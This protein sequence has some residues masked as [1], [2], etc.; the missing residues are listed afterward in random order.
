VGCC[1]LHIFWENVAEVRAFAVKPEFARQGIGTKLAQA[2]LEEAEEL[3]MKEVFTLTYVPGFFK[4]L[5][6]EITDK[7]QLPR[8]VWTGCLACPKFPDCDEIALIKKLRA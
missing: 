8:K 1:A 6:F 7:N 5:G 2:C 4:K 3:G